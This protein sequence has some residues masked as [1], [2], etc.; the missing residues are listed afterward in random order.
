MELP[1]RFSNPRKT[2]QPEV[3]FKIMNPTT[4]DLNQEIELDQNP[5]G[6][7]TRYI[8][9]GDQNLEDPPTALTQ[10]TF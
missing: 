4:L 8:S 3:S 6:G 5:T 1:W 7:Q 2:I 10:T 9:G